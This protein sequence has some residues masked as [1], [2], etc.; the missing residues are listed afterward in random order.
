MPSTAPN[1]RLVGANAAA[2]PACEVGSP[3]HGGDAVQAYA[4]KAAADYEKTHAVTLVV[5]VVSS[6]GVGARLWVVEVE[7]AGAVKG[8]FGAAGV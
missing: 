5:F 6:S 7:A 4:E 3:R 2:T 8:V 1:C